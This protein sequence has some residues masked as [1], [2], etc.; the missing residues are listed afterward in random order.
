MLVVLRKRYNYTVRCR[1]E[2]GDRG[3]YRTACLVFVERITLTFRNKRASRDNGK[4]FELGIYRRAKRSKKSKH[5]QLQHYYAWRP[6]GQHG[7]M[8]KRS[9][10]NPSK[11]HTRNYYYYYFFQFLEYQNTRDGT[12]ACSCANVGYSLPQS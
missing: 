6:S 2:N 8:S 1:M 10:E 5:E 12:G 7:E 4:R 3:Q 9:L 11:N